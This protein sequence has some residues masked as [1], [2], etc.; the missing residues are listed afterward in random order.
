MLR[1]A[2]SL[3]SYKLAVLTSRIREPR[4]NVGEPTTF[5]IELQ[6]LELRQVPLLERGR[7]PRR[8]VRLPRIERRVHELL[9]RGVVKAP[10]LPVRP[11]RVRAKRSR[12]ERQW[13]W[14]CGRTACEV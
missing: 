7:A 3:N 12:P 13:R 5:D 2:F 8:E 9:A 1:R 11:M 10:R 4:V 14:T 6:L